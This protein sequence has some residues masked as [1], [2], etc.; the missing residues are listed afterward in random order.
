MRQQGH[1]QLIKNIAVHTR[2]E[3]TDPHYIKAEQPGQYR[4]ALKTQG[5]SYKNADG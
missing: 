4:V 3:P 2:G 5:E 1:L